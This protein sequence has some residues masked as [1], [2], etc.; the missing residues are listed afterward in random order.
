MQEC[1]KKM[2]MQKKKNWTFKRKHGYHLVSPPPT[3]HTAYTAVR[4]QILKVFPLCSRVQTN[5]S[6]DSAD[7]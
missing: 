1:K 6:M 7:I 3:N 2:N 4:R 5:T